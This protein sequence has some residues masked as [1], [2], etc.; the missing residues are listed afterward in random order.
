MRNLRWLANLIVL[1]FFVGAT[2]AQEGVSDASPEN[3]LRAYAV[4]A[5][6]SHEAKATNPAHYIGVQYLMLSHFDSAL[7][8]FKA[9]YEIDKKTNDRQ[10]E[11]ASLQYLGK[12][13]LEMGDAEAGLAYLR[14]ALALAEAIQAKPKMLETYQ[15]LTDAFEKQKEPIVAYQ[16]LKS[17]TVLKDSMAKEDVQLGMADYQATHILQQKDEAL[18]MK[19]QEIRTI[20][21]ISIIGAFFALAVLL[22]LLY[23]KLSQQY[24]LND[25]LKQ[26]NLLIEQ[27]AQ[28]MEAFL[29]ER[30]INRT[31]ANEAKRIKIKSNTQ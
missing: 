2:Q 21:V 26:K 29:V 5:P 24:S 7:I 28:Q 20:Y 15:L 16:Y 8:Y 19:T 11:V 3:N 23:S 30:S 25:E 27:Q 6:L 12:T 4:A 31:I 13:C 9:S 10:G 18:T 1:L 17:Y 14:Q 22:W